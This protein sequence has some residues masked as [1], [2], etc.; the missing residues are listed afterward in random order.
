MTNLTKR[1]TYNVIYLSICLLFYKHG[2]E[3][4][5]LEASVL[6]V[7]SPSL[8]WINVFFGFSSGFLELDVCMLM[9]LVSWLKVTHAPSNVTHV[10]TNQCT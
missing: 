1:Q 4:V 8:F 2:I 3:A 7:S 10:R 5:C 9:S 6:L